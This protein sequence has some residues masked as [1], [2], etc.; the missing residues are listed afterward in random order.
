MRVRRLR[1]ALLR[2]ALNRK[3]AIAAGALLATPGATLL[4]IDR[5]WESW[6]TDGLALVSIATG[7]A[8]IGMGLSGRRPDW[9]DEMN[10]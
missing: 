3:T 4:A 9:Y 5:G 8:L 7:A 2:A 1:G 10:Q 6:F